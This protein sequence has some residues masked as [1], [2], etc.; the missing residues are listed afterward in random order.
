MTRSEIEPETGRDWFSQVTG[1]ESPCFSTPLPNPLWSEHGRRRRDVI[2]RD[3]G[4]GG[5]ATAA[6]GQ[7]QGGQVVGFWSDP[8]GPH[9]KLKWDLKPDFFPSAFGKH[10]WQK[11]EGLYWKCICQKSFFRWKIGH[12]L[13]SRNSGKSGC[14]GNKFSIFCSK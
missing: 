3:R 5:V 4:G 7:K 12:N 2:V 1:I 8:H 9:L 11:M 10:V 6:Y 14:I 13:T